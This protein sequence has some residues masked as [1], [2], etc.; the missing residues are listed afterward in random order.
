M[1][2]PDQ[3]PICTRPFEWAEIHPDGSLFLCC[4]A[5]L[6]RPI[7]NLLQQPIATIWN[8]PLAQE[9]RKSILN[10]SFHNCNSKRCPHLQENSKPVQSLNQV[11]AGPVKEALRQAS[12]RLDFLPRQLNLCFDQSCTLACPSCQPRVQQASGKTLEQ[13]EQ[14][15][16]I[17]TRQLLPGAETVTLSGFGDPFGSPT[18]L[19][20][21]RQMNRRD[22]PQLQ[23]LR[24]HS[25]GQLLTEAMWRS[26]PGLHKLLSEVEIS[27]DAASAETYRLNRPGGDFVTLLKNLEFISGLGC[28]L[29]LSMVVQANNWREIP[30]LLKLAERLGAKLY[31]S[32]M[33]NWGTFPREEFQRRAVAD[34]KHPQHAEFKSLLQQLGKESRIDFGNF[35]RLLG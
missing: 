27:I 24:L 3:H 22:Y 2:L 18:Y 11:P 26:L 32:C 28:Q 16:E 8:G 21:L 29:R 23:A 4:P 34:P 20:L 31:L 35:S 12:A 6:K 15:A 33:V 14:L 19:K 10:G 13:A 30:L 7:G 17:V 1:T 25:N 5:W 9:L